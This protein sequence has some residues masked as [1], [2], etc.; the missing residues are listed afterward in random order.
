MALLTAAAL[1]AAGCASVSPPATTAA[2]AAA[3]SSAPAAP[4]APAAPAA[5]SSPAAQRAAVPAAMA[6]ERKWLQSWFE[7]TPVL[8]AQRSDGAITIDVPR[9]FCFEPGRSTVKPAL[10]AVLN[11]VAESLLRVPLARLPLLAAP[12]DATGTAS[13]AAERA[14]QVQKHLLSRGVPAARLGKP[15]PSVAAA[16]QLRM[17]SPPSP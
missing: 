5:P 17:E 4:V 7:G 2:P 15:T 8:I 9:E 3:A 16:V 10:A 11:K 1:A 14:V 13:L 12:D 6:A